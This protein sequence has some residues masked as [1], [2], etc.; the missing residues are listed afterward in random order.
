MVDN[1]NQSAAV[2]P[3]LVLLGLGALAAILP[4]LPQDIAPR[5]SLSILAGLVVIGVVLNVVFVG[6]IRRQSLQQKKQADTNR[7]IV[8]WAKSRDG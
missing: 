5:V 3:V 8:E 1:K 4:F 6:N 2:W 7:M